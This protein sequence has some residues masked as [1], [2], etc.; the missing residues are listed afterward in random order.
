MALVAGVVIFVPLALYVAL[1]LTFTSSEIP[2]NIVDFRPAS[3]QATADTEFFYSIGNE[4]K[5]SDQI[6]PQA[7]TLMR[8]QIKN[9][10]VSPDNKKIAVVIMDD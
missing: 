7:P 9:F 8:G 5:Y 2:S 4:L 1:W 10:L 6:D 3:F